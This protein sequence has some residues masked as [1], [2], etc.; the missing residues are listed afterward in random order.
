MIRFRET[1]PTI[2]TL[3]S[4]KTLL[5]S[6]WWFIVVNLVFL[7]YEFVFEPLNGLR[8]GLWFLVPIICSFLL[9]RHG[10]PSAKENL[11]PII[12]F[13]SCLLVAHAPA[14]AMWGR[15]LQRGLRGFGAYDSQIKRISV[16][17]LGETIQLKPYFFGWY[18]PCSTAVE[19]T[20]I[21]QYWNFLKQTKVVC[22]VF[23]A[24]TGS[25][26]VSKDGRSVHLTATEGRD[27]GRQIDTTFDTEWNKVKPMNF[28]Q[29]PKAAP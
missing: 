3:P 1:N 17:R 11:Y 10:S 19:L 26:A 16:H 2:D 28:I 18:K 4:T 15:E 8:I 6:V 25:I 9:H 7:D 14:A 24:T 27:G 20:Y 23:P 29:I 21:R 22:Q 13:I 5:R 12:Y